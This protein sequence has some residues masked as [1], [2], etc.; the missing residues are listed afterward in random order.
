MMEPRLK[1]NKL[2]RSTDGGGSGLKFFKYFY[3]N[4]A[5]RLNAY[6]LCIEKGREVLF[7]Y[8]IISAQSYM[9]CNID[10]SLTAHVTSG[11]RILHPGTHF[12]GI[13]AYA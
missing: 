3:F 2:G 6:T 12:K 5:P 10:V 9:A 11:K 1:Y 7:F 13:I 8:K 4:M